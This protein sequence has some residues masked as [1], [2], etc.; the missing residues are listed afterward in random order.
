MQWIIWHV[1]YLCLWLLGTWCTNR[2][3][4]GLRHSFLSPLVASLNCPMTEDVLFHICCQHFYLCWR[5]GTIQSLLHLGWKKYNLLAFNIILTLL[6]GEHYL[7]RY[8][9]LAMSPLYLP[10][11]LLLMGPELWSLSPGTCKTGEKA[12]YFCLRVCLAE[13]V[14]FLTGNCEI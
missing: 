5:E 13:K 4:R 6:S 11:P 7:Q 2:K 1:T 14:I 12:L 8:L 9:F 10:C 3:S